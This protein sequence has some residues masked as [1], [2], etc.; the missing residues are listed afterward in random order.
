MKFNRVKS[1]HDVKGGQFYIRAVVNCHGDHWI[2]VFRLVGKAYNCDSKYM[3]GDRKIKQIGYRGTRHETDSYT[4]DLGI[5]RKGGFLLEYS[6]KL[7]NYLLSLDKRQ[8]NDVVW[9]KVHTDE[10]WKRLL[11][12][13]ECQRD[14]D[15]EMHRE[16]M[17]YYDEN[18]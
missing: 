8:F 13:W 3:K 15:E 17:R 6:N 10:E 7:Q 14:I 1:E 12:D 9:N 18:Y 11:L 4:G 5:A 16:M 2:E